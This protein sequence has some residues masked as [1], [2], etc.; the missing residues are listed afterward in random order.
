MT[1]FAQEFYTMLSLGLF[2]LRSG[3]LIPNPPLPNPPLP[4]PMFQSI[5]ITVKEYECMNMKKFNL[6]SLR[7]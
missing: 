6:N 2:R 3:G 5:I 7:F 1:M 4:N